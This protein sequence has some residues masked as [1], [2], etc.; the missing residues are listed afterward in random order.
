MIAMPV[1]LTKICAS[2]EPELI[3]SWK[4]AT[5]DRNTPTQKTA[6]DCWPQ[7]TS[8]SNIFHSSPGQSF[9]TKRVHGD[10]FLD[11]LGDVL[12]EA[13]HV[14]PGLVG[15]EVDEAFELGVVVAAGDVE[16]LLDAGHTDPGE[17]HSGRWL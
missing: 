4:C 8:G 9:G 10:D 5:N 1:T 7:T 12:F 6:S 14:H 16:E 17:A 3:V 2:S 15:S 13:R 11:R